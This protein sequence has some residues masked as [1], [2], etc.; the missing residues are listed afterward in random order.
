MPAPHRTTGRFDPASVRFNSEI[1]WDGDPAA[2]A[3]LHECLETLTLLLAPFVPFLT[4]E[5]HERL[6]HDV[7]PDLPESVHLREWPVADLSLVDEQLS[8]QMSQVRRLVE[9]G[10]AARAESGLKTRQPL[11]RAMVTAP[12]WDELPAELRAQL[13][14]ELNV[15]TVDRLSAAGD[16]VD[17]AYKGNFRLLGR[18]FQP[19]GG[20]RPAR[21]ER[22]D[23]RRDLDGGERPGGLDHESSEPTRHHRRSPLAERR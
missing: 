5:V 3:T 16:L 11:A 22:A 15:R 14:D 1:V 17:V 2:L 18:S 6:V 20:G 8:R 4:D 7:R 10:R 13:T 21:V 12:G 19:D 9:L 23:A